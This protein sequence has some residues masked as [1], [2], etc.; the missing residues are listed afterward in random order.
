[1][2]D[3]TRAV[4]TGVGVVSS[5]GIGQA[6]YWTNLSQGKS[7][8]KPITLFPAEEFPVGYGGEVSDFEF[9]GDLRRKPARTVD[10]ALQ[11]AYV[12]SAEAL[13]Q[14]SLVDDEDRV[15]VD[16]PVATIVGSGHGPCHEVE[17]SM[18]AYYRQGLRA[19]NP[20]AIPRSMY[21]SISGNLSIQFGLRGPN[22]VIVSACASAS[23]AIGEAYRLI[24]RGDE[25]AVLCGGTDAPLCTTMFSAWSRMR[26]MAR[27][28]NP[29][30]ACRPFDA[31]RK[32]LVLGEGAG[33]LLVEAERDALERDAE[34]LG[35]IE[36]YGAI[37][38]AFHITAPQKEGMLTAM[39]RCLK[40]AGVDPSE[41]DYVNAH[42]TGTELNDQLEAEAVFELFGERTPR[43]PI[44]STKS[45]LGHALGASGGLELIATLMAIRNDFIPPTLNCDHPDPQLPLDYCP[46]QGKSRPLN[47]A[48]SNSFAFGGNNAVLL[49]RSYD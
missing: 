29:Q 4:I 27:N 40:D 1:M 41:V 11:M 32:G 26:I 10:R 23:T 35:V 9:P 15:V 30:A 20:M 13:R 6:D 46:H 42:G 14:A 16:Y 43:M 19:V 48:I 7:G 5:V 37:S 28:D 36:G 44:S 25:R 18:N 22:H 17:R 21:N 31:D 2:V 38:D 49:I 24:T 3:A 34:I 12:A 45:A 33:M 39:K 47:V 8:V